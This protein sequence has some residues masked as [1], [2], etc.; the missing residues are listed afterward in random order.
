[1]AVEAVGEGNGDRMSSEAETR[2]KSPTTTTI[3]G[4]QSTLERGS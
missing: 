3:A 2:H 1:M 4:G